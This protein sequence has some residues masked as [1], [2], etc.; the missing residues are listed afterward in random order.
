MTSRTRHVALLR[1]LRDGAHHTARDL[2]ARLNVSDRTIWRDM[3]RLRASGV[4]IEGT[5][6][7]GYRMPAAIA[8]PP[9]NL[10]EDEFEALQLGLAI[11]GEAA[12]PGLRAA[13]EGLAAKIDASTAE[14]ALAGNEAWL[15]LTSQFQNAA[16]GFAHLAT[17]RAAIRARQKLRL[18]YH[19]RGDR[20][21]TRIVRPLETAFVGRIWTL[22]AWCEWRS[23]FRV[24]RVDLIETAEACPELFSDEAGK[25]LKDYA[26]GL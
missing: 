17:L 5:R 21:T 11:V 15:T 22:T 6:G 12:D 8:L 16:R 14:R 10:S 9:L 18:V 24:F 23:A 4:E 2:A 20:M 1:L 3:D 7:T 25:T 19:S 26:G 13:A